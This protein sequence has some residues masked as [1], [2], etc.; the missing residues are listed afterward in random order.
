MK[1][2]SLPQLLDQDHTSLQQIIEGSV[3]SVEQALGACSAEPEELLILIVFDKISGVLLG[4]NS[5]L[6]SPSW[7]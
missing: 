6:G 4:Y 3:G 2:V 5:G 1:E 7:F